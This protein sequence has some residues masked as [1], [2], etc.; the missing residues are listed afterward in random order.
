MKLE[1]LYQLPNATNDTDFLQTTSNPFRSKIS[2]HLWQL[3][4]SDTWSFFKV[5]LSCRK[6]QRLYV[7]SHALVG[8]GPQNCKQIYFY[9]VFKHEDYHKVQQVQNSSRNLFWNVLLLDQQCFRRTFGGI[10]N[11]MPLC[12]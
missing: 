6:S 2:H 9:E 12:D 8:N 7:D 5:I 11:W 1:D 10:Y 3:Y 4:R